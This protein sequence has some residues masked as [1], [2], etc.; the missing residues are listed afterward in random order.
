MRGGSVNHFPCGPHS[1]SATV[2][3]PMFVRVFDT[4]ANAFSG[5]QGF[6]RLLAIL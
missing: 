4:I 3:G 6:L 1:Y 5:M 2:E